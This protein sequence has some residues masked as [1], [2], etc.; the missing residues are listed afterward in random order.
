VCVVYYVCV[1]VCVRV[2]VCIVQMCHAYIFTCTLTH[3]PGTELEWKNPNFGN[4]DNIFAACLSLF[5]VSSMEMWPD[6]MY[7][8]GTDTCARAR[9]CVCVCVCASIVTSYVCKRTHIHT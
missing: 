9:V 8:A 7:R 5:E 1:C 3:M 6:F 4:F 2:Q